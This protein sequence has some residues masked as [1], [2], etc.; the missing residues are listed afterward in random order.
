MACAPWP[1][2]RARRDLPCFAVGPQTAAEARKAGLYRSAQRRWR[3]QGAGPGRDRAGPPDKGALLHV[4][5]EDSAGH[6]GG[7]PRLARLSRCAAEIL[8]AVDAGDS[9]PRRGAR[10]ACGP[11]SWMRRMFFSPR[12]ARIFARAWPDGSAD[13]G[14][15]RLC[16]SPATAAGAVAAC[17]LPRI[18]VA[19]KPNQDRAAGPAGLKT[20]GLGRIRQ[21]NPPHRFTKPKFKQALAGSPRLCHT[22]RMQHEAFANTEDFGGP[23]IAAAPQ[24]HLRVPARMRPMPNYELG[25]AYDEMFTPRRQ[26]RARPM[27]RWTSRISTLPLEEL[28]RRQ[29]ACEQSFL[30]QGITFTVYNDNQATER[31]IPTDLLPRIVTAAEW[32]RI[33]ARPDPAHPRAQSFPARHLQRRPG[34]EGRRRAALHDLRLQALS[35]RDARAAGA[36]WRLCQYLRQRSDPQRGRRIRR[37]GRQSARAVRRLLHAGQPRCGA[38]R[39]SRRVPRA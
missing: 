17:L 9:L 32:E 33:E 15:D 21:R 28:N 31:I 25:A 12:S 26:A 36:A 6:A 3:C 11:G 24:P 35:P 7:K 22:S 23:D 34:A 4:C 10:S 16:I 5:G 19:A 14:S 27:P 18:A 39:L 38:P 20:V 13:G 1:A 29:Q 30:H 37:A 2:A 8:Y